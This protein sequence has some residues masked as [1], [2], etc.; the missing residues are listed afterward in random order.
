M[1][2]IAALDA[3]IKSLAGEGD[4]LTATAREASSSTESGCRAVVDTVETMH[5]L[6]TASAEATSAMTAL[7]ERSSKVGEIVDSI[8]EIADQ[9]NLLAPACKRRRQCRIRYSK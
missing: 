5:K 1:Q 9:T 8:E 7:E 3:S 6:M 4:T 2:A